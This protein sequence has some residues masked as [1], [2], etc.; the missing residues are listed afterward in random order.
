M[1][2]ALVYLARGTNIHELSSVKNFFEDYHMY[3]PGCQHELIVIAKGW[4]C[5]ERQNELQQLSQVNAAKVIELPDDGFDLGAYMRLAPLLSHDWV[6]FLNTHSRPRVSGWLNLL[7][8]T[9]E[10][11]GMNVGAVSATASLET[12]IAFCIVFK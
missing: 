2:L 9:A 8:M 3:S 1:S 7:R 6:C 4:T 11:S 5:V 10:V 12:L